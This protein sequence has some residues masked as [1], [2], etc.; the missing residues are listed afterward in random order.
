MK[1]CFITCHFPPLSRTY[2]RYQFARYLAD[3]GC[4]VE[5]VTHGNISRALGAW[6][7]DPDLVVDDDDLVVH[8]PRAVPWYL[9][10]ELL[11]RIGL[12]SCPHL[13]WCGPATRA[14]RRVAASPEDVVVGVYPPLTNL[15]AAYRTARRTGARLVVDF[16]DE[17]LGLALGPRRRL[18]RKWQAR[19]LGAA[20]LVS[21]ATPAI[22]RNFAER[23]GLSPDRVHV[24]QNGYF[25][26]PGEPPPPPGGD[27]VRLVYAGAISA[28]QGVDVLCRALELLRRDKPGLAAQVR[29]TIHGPDNAYRRA[30][31]NSALVP[32]VEY[33]GYLSAGEVS[34]HL[35]SADVCFLSLSS[36]DYAYAIPGKLYEYI[37]HGRP[38]LA[39]LPHGAARE[40]I[41]SAGFG[42]VADCGDAAGLARALEQILDPEVRRALAAQ[43]IAQRARYAAAPNF[44]SLA[45]RMQAL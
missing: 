9:S 28:I 45:E 1:V 4:Q 27:E 40:L 12:I 6:V 44:L 17:Y 31:L 18:A 21:V 25:D 38:I 3:G 32:G 19:L 16:R 23:D 24:T 22:A 5:V 13:N 14:A 7:D 36:G 11:Y 8:R 15:I 34:G 20:D 30:V 2:R 37:A 39:A 33:G 43:V 26:D 10:G 42:L 41:E 29:A 35:H